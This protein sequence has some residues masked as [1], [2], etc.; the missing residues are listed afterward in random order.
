MALVI[1]HK[2]VT[3]NKV[4]HVVKSTLQRDATWINMESKAGVLQA[5]T[6]TNCGRWLSPL[7]WRWLWISTFF[8]MCTRR[9]PGTPPC[10]PSPPAQGSVGEETP[11]GNGVLGRS[12]GIWC[13]KNVAVCTLPSA[14]KCPKKMPSRQRLSAP[15]LARVLA[16][17]HPQDDLTE[18]CNHSWKAFGRPFLEQAVCLWLPCAEQAVPRNLAFRRP[19]LDETMAS[20]SD[21]T[22]CRLDRRRSF[23]CLRC[24]LVVKFRNRFTSEFLF[25]CH[26]VSE[27]L[28]NTTC[29]LHI[30]SK[31]LSKRGKHR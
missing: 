7:E 18:W 31:P 19:F 17:R 1:P 2:H 5:N 8:L 3:V 27:T 20:Q 9:K 29:C 16:C 4:N 14:K 21:L 23:R 13:S 15:I 30:V 26:C 10:P 6:Q 22:I 28:I 12:H 25:S 24:Q 11:A